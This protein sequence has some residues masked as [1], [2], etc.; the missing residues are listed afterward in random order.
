MGSSNPLSNLFGKSPFKPLQ[1]HMRQVVSCASEVPA[2][3]E[4]LNA[5]DEAKIKEIKV[6]IDDLEGQADDTKDQL[7][8]H[9][10]KSLF[11]PIDRRDLLDLLSHQDNIA[12]TAQSI[13]ELLSQRKMEV[14]VGMGDLLVDLTKGGVDAC[15]SAAKIIEELD[16]LVEMGFGGR[17]STRVLEMVEA[18]AK[19]EIENSKKTKELLSNL[20]AHENEIKPVSVVLWYQLINWIGDLSGGAE[21]VGDRLRLLLAR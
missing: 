3:F 14:P 18:L 9:L 12:D 20:F 5:G 8:A 1:Q 17:E 4:A 21:K 10:P 15:D 13:A 11:M 2:L 7:R 16:E 6:R 19:L